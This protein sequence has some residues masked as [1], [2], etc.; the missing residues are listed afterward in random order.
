MKSFRTVYIVAA[1]ISIVLYAFGVMT[2]IYIQKSVLSVVESDIDSIRQNV[3]NAQQEILLF[4]FR[5]KES[6]AVL[7]SL[8]T[9]IS[10]KLSN[11]ANELIRLENEGETGTKFVELKREYG[12]LTIRAWILRSSIN[13]NCNEGILPILYYYSVPCEKCIEQGRVIDN[14]IEEGFRE[15]ISV[16]ALDKDIDHA[17][18]RTLV[19][20]HGIAEAPSLVIEKDVYQGFINKENLT[21][22]ICQRT[23]ATICKK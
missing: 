12:S 7:S 8:S 14:I 4:S 2:G 1:I 18:V 13:A 23:N 16:Y 3:E 11:L 5:G 9:E 19:K 6:C 20:S 15:H 22:V 10:S 17:L 21:D